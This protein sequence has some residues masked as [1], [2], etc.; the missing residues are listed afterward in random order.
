MSHLPHETPV[1][2]H[3]RE[4]RIE[5]VHRLPLIAAF[6]VAGLVL[7]GTIVQVA[8]KGPAAER[9]P[10]LTAET[11]RTI[12]VHDVAA[13]GV[14]VRDA[15]SGTVLAAHG[16]GQGAFLRQALRS[17]VMNRERKGV[18]LRDPFTVMRATDGK[19][20]VVDGASGTR[21]NVTA[22]GGVARANFAPLLDGAGQE[23]A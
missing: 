3:E 14:E 10:A 7:V 5:G 23:G 1:P 18:P 16:R 8:T 6:G 13:G 22:F 21:I 11:Q 17:L 9:R 15:T 20:Y 12:T 4:D 19:L 2:E